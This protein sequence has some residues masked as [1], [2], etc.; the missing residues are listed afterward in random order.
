MIRM[1]LKP[2]AQIKQIDAAQ[3]SGWLTKPNGGA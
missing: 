1:E 2:F 3:S